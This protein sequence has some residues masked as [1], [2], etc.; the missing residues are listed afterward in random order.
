M[1]KWMIGC[2]TGVAALLVM[3]TAQADPISGKAAKA[4]M[5]GT[6]AEV[7]VLDGTGLPADMAAALKTVLAGQPYYGAAAF[8][9]DEGLMSEATVFTGNYHDVDAASKA[10]IQQCDAKR[11]GKA[12]CVVAAIVRPKGYKTRD[13]QLSAEASAGFKSGYPAA[14]GALAISPSTGAW[15]IGGDE[16]GAVA[17][18]AGQAKKTRDCVVVIS[19]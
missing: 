14:G 15:G 11:K 4:M 2:A 7:V 3:G 8:S 5:F 16:A 17:A 10:A 18:C 9:P 13:L 19:N 12:H 1:G 6:K